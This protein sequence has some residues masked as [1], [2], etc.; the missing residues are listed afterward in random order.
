M[1]IRHKVSTLLV[2]LLMHFNKVKMW[3]K[4]NEKQTHRMCLFFSFNYSDTQLL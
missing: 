1:V 4:I 3:I 2:E